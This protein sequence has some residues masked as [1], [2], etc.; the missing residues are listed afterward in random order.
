MRR[1]APR[2][3]YTPRDKLLPD[4]LSA[5]LAARFHW[6]RLLRQTVRED[7]VRPA[8]L[9]DPVGQE[10]R[11]RLFPPAAQPRP[12][13]PLA[14]LRSLLRKWKAQLQPRYFS[15]AHLSYRSALSSTTIAIGFLPA[16]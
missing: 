8:A 16:A 14:P 5:S 9:A 10:D 4:T 7:P 6:L 1:S 15:H 11:L 12:A 13:L 2:P 3:D